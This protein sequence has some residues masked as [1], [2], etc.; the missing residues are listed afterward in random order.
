M[1]NLNSVVIEGEIR[2]YKGGY[3]NNKM[4]YIPFDV[5]VKRTYATVTGTREEE[6][7]FS[8]E[9]CGKMAENI[10]HLMEDGKG[11]RLVGRLK[12]TKFK[13]ETGKAHSKIVIIAEHIEINVNRG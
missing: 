7:V 1:N 11:V 3:F 9:A 13:D 6:S 5:V 8:V 2:N 10:E 4:F 12:Q